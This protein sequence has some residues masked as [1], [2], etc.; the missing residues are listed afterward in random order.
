MSTNTKTT[1]LDILQQI[2]DLRGESTTD[3]G[4]NRIRFVSRAERDF[5]RRSFR[6]IFLLK[7]QAVVG[8]AGG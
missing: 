3:T 5:A 8:S 6:R 4:A 2:S 7:D 1:V